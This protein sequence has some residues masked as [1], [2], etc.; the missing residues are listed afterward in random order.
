MDPDRVLYE[1]E[2]RQNR[3][4]ILVQNSDTWGRVC[5]AKRCV[6]VVLGA[7]RDNLRLCRACSAD[8]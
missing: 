2:T 8:N 6:I 7:S 1:E 3:K 4:L 5:I